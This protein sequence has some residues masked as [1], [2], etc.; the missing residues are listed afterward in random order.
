MIGRGNGNFVTIKCQQ[1]KPQ[2]YGTGVWFIDDQVTIDEGGVYEL[3][4][5]VHA[6]FQDSVIEFVSSDEN[7]LEIVSIDSKKQ[8]VTVKGLKKGSAGITIKVYDDRLLN[9]SNEDGLENNALTVTIQ[10]ESDKVSTVK[11]LLW[12]SL[13]LILAIVIYYIVVGVKKSKNFEVK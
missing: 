3:K 1:L 5:Y 11:I 13:G 10:K 8:I 4:Y 12:I 9:S 7:V 2:N 6:V